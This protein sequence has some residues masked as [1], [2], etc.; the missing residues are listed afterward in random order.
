MTAPGDH[1]R[2]VDGPWPRR[3]IDA[4]SLHGLAHPLRIAML[5]A[6]SIYGEATASMLATRLGVSSGATSYHLRQLARHGFVEERPELGTARERWW[7]R[8]PGAISMARVDL[9][10][11]PA[12]SEAASLV[13]GEF[14][15]AKQARREHWQRTIVDWDESWQDASMDSTARVRLTA[16][17]ATELQH[18]ID[19]LLEGWVTRTRSRSVA[20][21]FTNVEVQVDMFPV[22]PPPTEPA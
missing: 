6:L 2:A 17:E 11:S 5:D 10:A 14:S 12:T 3:E 22:G 15:R 13:L 9:L 18:E 8:I 21:G 16:D 1:D 7:R 20:D 19:G 4:S